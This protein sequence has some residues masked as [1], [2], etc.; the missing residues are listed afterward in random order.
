MIIQRAY[1]TQL[2]PTPS[3]IEAFIGHSDAVRWVWNWALAQ[4][5]AYYEHTGKHLPKGE[6]IKQ[7]RAGKREGHWPWLNPMN[8]RAEEA[9]LDAQDRAF[10]RFWKQC[11][12]ELPKPPPGKPRKDGKPRGYPRFRSRKE[13]VMSFC[14]WG[15]R[16]E[17]I[18]RDRIR[19]QG[20]GWVRLQEKGYLPTAA[21]KVNRATVSERV[22]KW[23]VSVQVEEEVPDEV[24]TGEPVGV[25]VGI[26]TLAVVSDGREFENPKALRKAQRKLARL[27][28]K[29]ARQKKGSTRREE[30]KRKIARLHYRVG[31]L[32]ATAAH[33]VSAEI[34][35]RH[36]PPEDRPAAVVIEDL[37]VV[38][39]LQNGKL[40]RSISDAGFGELHRQVT[41]KGEWAGVTV[42]KADKWF[43]SSKTCSHCGYVVRG[44][45][46]GVRVFACPECGF[47][48]SRDVN[49]ALNLKQVAEESSET[50]NARGGPGPREPQVVEAR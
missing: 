19:L 48:A 28:R 32:R 49:A 23:F 46:L 21:R 18:D 3:Q 36:R 15:L 22:G 31:N 30:T 11:R 39:M 44:M 4:R 10:D 20:I 6:L 14:F 1:R 35:G 12:G 43:A 24:A 41:Y 26:N 33:E 9:A 42:V 27:Q 13:G 40:A 47:S 8:S 17:H 29:V 25:D 16:P 50:E 7:F 5:N 38:G 2:N 34:V 45:G 37:N